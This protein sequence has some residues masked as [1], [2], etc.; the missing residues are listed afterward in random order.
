MWH[1]QDILV[2]SASAQKG[3]KNNFY[4]VETADHFTTCKPRNKNDPIYKKLLE[5]LE[6]CIKNDAKI[7]ILVDNQIGK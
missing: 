7:N 2:P 1:V 4:K 3:A 6:C 5:F